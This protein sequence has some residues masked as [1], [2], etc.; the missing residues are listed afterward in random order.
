MCVRDVS[1]K[2]V[3]IKKKNKTESQAKL[4]PRQWGFNLISYFLLLLQGI[5]EEI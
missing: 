3:Q 1:A 5:K 2:W 4:L